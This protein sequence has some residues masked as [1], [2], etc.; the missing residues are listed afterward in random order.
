L[1]G[2]RYI[3]IDEKSGK[4][5]PP[6]ICD[7]YELTLSKL[8]SIGHTANLSKVCNSYL[9]FVKR[10]PGNQFQFYDRLENTLSKTVKQI[11]KKNKSEKE[12]LSKVRMNFYL[13]F[14][15]LS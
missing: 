13:V 5:T 4:S 11:P 10:Q 14:A 7:L 2:Y 15:L 3:L 9:D 1:I 12:A 8:Q 6:E